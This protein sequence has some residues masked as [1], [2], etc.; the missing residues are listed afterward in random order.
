[1]G[2]ETLA[3]IQVMDMKGVVVYQ[4]ENQTEIVDI[5]LSGWNEGV[6]LVC[7]NHNG[8]IYTKKLVIVQ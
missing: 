5:N 3:S 2:S 7:I 8:Q 4:A 6:Y 1:L